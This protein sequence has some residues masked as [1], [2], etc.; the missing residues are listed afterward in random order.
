MAEIIKKQR[1][2]PKGFPLLSPPSKGQSNSLEK[3]PHPTHKKTAFK[4]KPPTKHKENNTKTNTVKQQINAKQ[5]ENIKNNREDTKKETAVKVGSGK[6]FSD[7]V[8]MWK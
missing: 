1:V 6:N 7:L 3:G 2:P 4:L 8:G 5:P